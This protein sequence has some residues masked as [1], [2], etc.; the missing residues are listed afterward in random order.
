MRK[1]QSSGGSWREGGGRGVG[2]VKNE[3]YINTQI[4]KKKKK[5]KKSEYQ[6]WTDAVGLTRYAFLFNSFKARRKITPGNCV[7]AAFSSRTL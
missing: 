6:G 2:L 5:K 1:R 7:I 3:M 4:K